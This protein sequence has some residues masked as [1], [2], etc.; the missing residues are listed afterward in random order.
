MSQYIIVY[1]HKH[2]VYTRCECATGPFDCESDTED[3]FQ[4]ESNTIKDMYIHK[5]IPLM[6]D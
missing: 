5:I 2:E 1:F 6:K 3:Y 4:K